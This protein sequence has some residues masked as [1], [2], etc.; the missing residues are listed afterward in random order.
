MGEIIEA[1]YKF[2]DNLDKTDL[3]KNLTYYKQKLEKNSN[4]LSLVSRYNKESDLNK[5]ILL[6]K[7][8]FKNSDYQ[9]YM[10]YYNKL[11]FI[12]LTINKQYAKYT[13]TKEHNCYG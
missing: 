7:K 13:N 12:I 2:L 11:S 10:L 6:K 4:I 1:T 9:N 8:L 3:I 5:K